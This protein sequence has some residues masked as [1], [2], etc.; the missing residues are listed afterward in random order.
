MTRYETFAFL[1]TVGGLF[2]YLCAQSPAPEVAL[3]VLVLTIA[4]IIAAS[5]VDE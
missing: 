1:V 3:A 2:A 4:G 5:H